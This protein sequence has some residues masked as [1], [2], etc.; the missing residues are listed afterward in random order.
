MKAQDDILVTIAFDDELLSVVFENLEKEYDISFSYSND[1]I[2]DIKVNGNFDNTPL[3]LVLT[4]ILKKEKVKFEFIEEKYILISPDENKQI[5]EELDTRSPSLSI[6]GNIQDELTQDGLSYT[7]VY[8]LN[9]NIGTA[10]DENGNFKLKGRFSKI[11]SLEISFMGYET[12]RFAVREL[13]N[14][15][16]RNFVMKLDEYESVAVKVTGYL[17]DGIYLGSDANEVK[18]QP[19]KMNILPGQIEPDVMQSVLLLPGVISPDESA[20]KLHIRGGTPDQNLVLWDGIPMYH[21]GHFFGS[22]SAFNPYIVDEVNVWRGNFGPQYGGRVSGIIDINSTQKV[23]EK[24]KIGAGLNFTHGH[25]FAE[26]P[27]WKDKSALI[28]S[29]RRSFTD[30]WGSP[31]F[32]NLKNK[33]FQGTKVESNEDQNE[34]E[35]EPLELINNFSF[36][37]A[38]AKWLLNPTKKDK[39]YVSAFTGRNSLDYEVNNSIEDYDVR[40]ELRLKNWGISGEWGRDW[41]DKL[42]SKLNAA[43]SDFEYNYQYLITTDSINN[44]IENISKSNTVEDFRLRLES[45]YS[46]NEQHEINTGYHF[47]IQNVAF[48]INETLLFEPNSEESNNGKG[49]TQSVFLDYIFQNEKWLLNGGLRYNYFNRAT[50]HSV[51]P[52]FSLQWQAIPSLRLKLNG[53]LHHQFISQLVELEFNTLGV[54]NEIWILADEEENSVIKSQQLAA[55]FIFKKKGWQVDVEAYAKKLSNIA[56][57]STSFGSQV[58]DNFSSGTSDILGI[59]ILLKKRWKRYRSWISYTWSKANYTF[60]ELSNNSFPAFHDQRHTLGWMHLFKWHPLEISLGWNYHSGLPFTALSSTEIETFV[61][62]EGDE[63]VIANPLLGKINSTRLANYHRLDFS[64]VYTFPHKLTSKWKGRLG[65]SLT[66]IYNRSNVFSTTYS[67][68]IIDEYDD[69][70]DIEVLEIEKYLLE[71]TP[72]ILFRIE[73]N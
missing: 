48:N 67:E 59:D 23:S 49:K 55:G 36:Y 73:W 54:N 3:S 51:E 70:N 64:M 42:S 6:C 25:A 47:T 17:M 10:T 24:I 34:E 40:D 9:S 28:V 68:S 8:I 18:I 21:T 15:P 58:T 4:A 30:L 2:K 45:K 53:G 7:N 52:R 61:D 50:A 20:S 37:D 41:N 26:I 56:S 19:D 5:E 46:F 22:I 69:P 12:Q 66:N 14:Q 31:T 11:D 29:Y 32:N 39:I 13:L 60:P 65:F 35:E 38:N 1:L 43:Y 62:E 33:I 63:Y 57:L 44:P 72:N 27:I 16:C 71:F